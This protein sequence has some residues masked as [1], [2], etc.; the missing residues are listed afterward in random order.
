[1]AAANKV[2]LKTDNQKRSNPASIGFLEIN[3]QAIFIPILHYL[4]YETAL[5][6]ELSYK[7]EF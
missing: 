7:P 3:F 4:T 6:E 1:M 5:V 2:L